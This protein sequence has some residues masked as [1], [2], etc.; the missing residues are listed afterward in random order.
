MKIG[1]DV[2][3]RGSLRS[4]LIHIPL[5]NNRT[6]IGYKIKIKGYDDPILIYESEVSEHRL[7]R[8]TQY[9]TKTDFD[10]SRSFL[11]KNMRA[12]RISQHVT[13]A[14]LAD[15]I[16]AFDNSVNNWEARRNAPGMI[17]LLRLAKLMG[18][19]VEEM[20]CEEL[21]FI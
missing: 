4:D 20:C 18:S 8:L 16:G 14:E 5:A 7:S 1:S 21:E 12:F 3:I 17:F 6:F 19:T 13:Q 10:D 9:V 11:A 15:A 2:N